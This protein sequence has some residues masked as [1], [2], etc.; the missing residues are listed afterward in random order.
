MTRVLRI[1]SYLGF[2]LL[3]LSAHAA[4]PNRETASLPAGPLTLAQAVSLLKTRGLDLLLADAAV[5]TSAGEA[6]GAHAVA[7]PGLNA[8]VAK[9]FDC[10]SSGCRWLP[11]VGW[12]VGLSDSNALFD[13]ATGKRGLRIDAAEAGL[14][15]AQA[16][17][18]DVERVL[19]S[20]L[21]QQFVQTLLLQQ[22]LT[23]A[24]E[25]AESANRLAE[26]SRV[27]FRSGAISEADLARV[28][29]DAME[30]AQALDS[31]EL[32]LKTAQHGLAVL[33]G[34]DSVSPEFRV[35]EP[36]LLAAGAPPPL[37]GEPPGGL[38]EEALR[39]RPDVQA[40]ESQVARAEA[41][42]R[43]ARRQRIPDTGLALNYVQQG[44]NEAA[45]TP[46]TF[47]LGL[48]TALPIFYQQQGEIQR[49][50]AEL[51]TQ[52]LHLEKLRRQ[53]AAD[54][55]GALRTFE[56][57][58][59]L[60]RRMDGGLLERAGRARDLVAFQYQKGA[61]SLLEL[62]DAQRT[63]RLITI[64]RYQNLAAY[65]TAVFRLEEVVGGEQPAKG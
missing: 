37:A 51:T 47:T 42:S 30:T 26:L 11:P 19:V 8:S 22:N 64:E 45:I 9:S 62:I 55:L 23:S 57:S 53:V 60:L 25:S 17:R 5:A 3:A 38:I 46:P 4:P 40:L 65:W 16:T 33:L 39:R 49:A 32:A 34:F 15:S 44:T 12:G 10:P 61:A 6:R 13:T 28:E 63:F 7:N 18:R 58:Q 52:R 1:L 56:T 20:Q 48:T 54:V 21:R 59:R 29:T 43:L 35:E 41:S 24:H 27:R 36:T 50:D 14:L 31:A 2:V